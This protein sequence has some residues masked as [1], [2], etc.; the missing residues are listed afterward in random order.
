MRRCSSSPGTVSS[1]WAKK[2]NSWRERWM[3]RRW[4]SVLLSLTSIP[5]RKTTELWA[6]SSM[7]RSVMI[8]RKTI[9]LK[10]WGSFLKI[11]DRSRTLSGRMPFWAGKKL[12]ETK[13]AIKSTKDCIR[14]PKIKIKAKPSPGR[15]VLRPSEI[16]RLLAVNGSGESLRAAQGKNHQRLILRKTS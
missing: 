6:N 5:V 16:T 2:F 11:T 15:R 4:N 1:W 14:T 9:K 8:K 12:L 10:R 13:Q 3:R 7:I